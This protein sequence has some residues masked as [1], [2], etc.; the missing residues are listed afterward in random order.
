LIRNLLAIKTN[1]DSG[2]FL[3]ILEAAAT[4]MSGDQTWIAG[5]NEIYRQRRDLVISALHRLGLPA[6]VP[7]ASLYVWTPIPPG[8]KAE[9]F[10]ASLLEHAH[11]SLTPGTVFGSAGEGYLRISLTA[12]LEKLAEAMQ[13]WMNT[14]ISGLSTSI[15]G[16]G[17]GVP[18]LDWVQ[19]LGDGVQS[20]ERRQP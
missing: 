3:P 1:I 10:A 14:S 7:Q 11:V 12:P 18:S 6:A 13:R 2:H 16:Q 9:A 20:L 15:G 5:R 17:D 4:A 19:S 8:W